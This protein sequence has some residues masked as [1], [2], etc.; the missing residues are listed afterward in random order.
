[1]PTPAALRAMRGALNWSLRDLATEAGLAV[2][3]VLAIEKGQQVSAR[4][5]QR[6]RRAF[7]LR[8]VSVRQDG[9]SIVVRIGPPPVPALNTPDALRKLPYVVV[10]PRADGTWRV[11][12]E[13]PAR[14]RPLGWP[15]TRPLPV[16][17]RTGQLEA[18]EVAAIRADAA[19]MLADLQGAR[20]TA[21]QDRR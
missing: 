6:V 1:M 8:G 14:I 7:R 21:C 18:E 4:S 15:A 12:F 13:V 10:R 20:S 5:I 19:K 3:T 17:G 11:L 9:P 16:W 2:G